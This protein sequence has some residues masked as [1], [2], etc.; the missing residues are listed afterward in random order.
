MT[1]QVFA[2]GFKKV[3]RENTI[4]AKSRLGSGPSFQ[5]PGQQFVP[6]TLRGVVISGSGSRWEGEGGQGGWD[7]VGGTGGVGEGGWDWWR[8]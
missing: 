1:T 6:W 7:R 8:G 3:E 2:K 4:F 5:P